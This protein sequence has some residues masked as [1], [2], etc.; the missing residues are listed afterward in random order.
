M[1]TK[2]RPI[3][4][5]AIGLFF[6][7]PLVAPAQARAA[8]PALDEQI[9]AD[10]YVYLIGRALVVRQEHLDIAAQGG[11]NV[12]FHNRLGSADF[13]NPNLGVAN[14]EAW[15]AVDDATPVVLELPKIERRYYTAQILDEWGETLTNIHERNYPLQPYGKFAFVAPGSRVAIPEDAV[16]IELRSQKAKMLA[17]V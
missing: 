17:R 2:L 7:V 3:Q 16:R 4:V 15:I 6:L 12:A 5:L 13:V 8:S 11:Y 10:A 9:I 14:T 1:S